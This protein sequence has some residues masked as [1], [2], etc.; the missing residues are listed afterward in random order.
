MKTKVI[1]LVAAL[2][3]TFSSNMLAQMDECVVTASLFIEPA[4]AKN[5]DAALPHYDKVIKECPTYSLATYQY[6]AKMF[7]HFIKKGDKSKIANYESNYNLMKTNYPAKTKVG[8]EM[9][10]IA[11]I[12]YDNKME[13]KEELFAAFDKAYKTDEKTFTSPKSLYTY[14][15][16]AKDLYDEGKKDIQEVFDL[17]DVMQ[18]KI[19]KEEV[20]YAGKLSKLIEKEQ[21]GTALTAK[22]AKKVKG[23]ETNLGSYGKIKGSIDTKLGSIADCSNLVPLYEKLWE[24]KKN[25]V[26]WLKSAA[27]K[28]NSRDCDTPMFFQMVQQ[29]HTLQPSASSAFYLGRLAAKDG[30]P[31]QAKSYYEQAIELETDPNQKVKYYYNLAENYRKKGSYGQAR[32]YYRDMLDIKPNAGSAYLKIASMYA[33]SANNCGSKPFEKRAINWLAAQ[34]ADKAARVDPS[35]ASTARSAASSYRQRAPSKSDIFSEGMAGKTISFSCWVGGSV[36]VPNL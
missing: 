23:Y 29:L 27:G 5:Y 32:K 2:T 14:F 24:E 8:K 28:L 3:L 20:K 11:Q 4:K 30:K 31:S 17:Y 34:M 19:S 9:A 26:S 22:E 1:L 12:K 6:G 35:I 18:E 7:E 16:L 36:R 15:S 10:K 33:K 13:A 21:G 25:D